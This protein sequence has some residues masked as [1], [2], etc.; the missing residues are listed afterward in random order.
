MDAET[1][2]ICPCPVCGAQA[3]LDVYRSTRADGV[4]E[5]TVFRCPNV[6]TRKQQALNERLCRK[7]NLDR[8]LVHITELKLEESTMPK[9]QPELR[10]EIVEFCERKNLTRKQF[11]QM[12][13]FKAGTIDAMMGGAPV[14][15]DAAERLRESL[16]SLKALEVATESKFATIDEILSESPTEL[17][18][19]AVN[20]TPVEQEKLSSSLIDQLQNSVKN[21]EDEIGL[22]R[23]DAQQYLAAEN[24]ALERISRLESFVSGRI[25][26]RFEEL[27]KASVTACL[28][29]NPTSSFEQAE[30]LKQEARRLLV[31]DPG[32]HLLRAAFQMAISEGPL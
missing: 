4:Y 29:A 24:T 23:Q 10:Q 6:I 13:N 32:G 18:K 19:A 16:A 12:V 9:I 27:E 5:V 1:H 20:S 26:Q 30:K 21:L 15:S 2:L 8:H 7:K 25:A 3:H 22:L 11:A 14:S 31:S 28:T 17:N